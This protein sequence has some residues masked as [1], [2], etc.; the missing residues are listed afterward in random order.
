MAWL[1]NRLVL[2]TDAVMVFV[3]QSK[4]KIGPNQIDFS[5]LKS[6]SVGLQK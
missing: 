2:V 6:D 3:S 1:S 5:L 4:L